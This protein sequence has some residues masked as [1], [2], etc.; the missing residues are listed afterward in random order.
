MVRESSTTLTWKALQRSLDRVV[1]VRALK[2]GSSES[3]R[4][5][6]EAVARAV[7]K[8]KHPN[9]IQAFD[10]ARQ[11]D[12]S[13][14]IVLEAV[15]G[16]TLAELL[17]RET[18]MD[19]VRVAKIGAGVADALDAAWK[20]TSLIH[21]NLKPENLCVTHEG[22][23]KIV[24]FGAATLIQPGV[25]PLQHDGGLIVGTPNYMA[26]EQAQ[27][28][29]DLDFHS[30][31]YGLGALLYHLVTGVA[32]FGYEP[33]PHKT[34]ELQVTGTL[35]S[36]RVANPKVPGSLETVLARLMMKDP[37]AR[38]DWWQDAVADLQ[39][40]SLGRPIPKDKGADPE[41]LGTL[42]P[43]APPRRSARRQSTS[44]GGA[45][46]PAPSR[47]S[48]LAEARSENRPSP[49]EPV[50][51][52]LWVALLVA[53]AGLAVYRWEHP[54]ATGL[55]FAIPG[56]EAVVP[57]APPPLPV[58][59]AEG[60]F[61]GTDASVRPSVTELPVPVS[62]APAPPAVP[63]PDPAQRQ[64]SAGLP[65]ALLDGVVQCLGRE[66]L[67]SA[68]GILASAAGKV[69][70]SES[71]RDAALRL[72]SSL[73]DPN[74]VV[75]SRFL[76]QSKGR[77]V[78]LTYRGRVV[79]LVP[80][81]YAAGYVGAKLL[82]ADGSSHPWSMGLASLPA[83][84]RLRLIGAAAAPSGDPAADA[85]LAILA[86]AADDRVL[87]RSMAVHVPALAPFLLH[88]ANR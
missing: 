59:G 84:E 86:V 54:E 70:T 20:Q 36:P 50:R 62:T 9:L 19:P 55:P 82:G 68:R 65:P 12:G 85:A 22:V 71:E 3:Q 42:A 5:A 18:Q 60:P 56:G 52:A 83:A 78:Q 61:P 63:L 15:E 39:R 14:Y 48:A 66:D 6:F 87:A 79:S 26:P 51:F 45:R 76:E 88:A 24:E 58:R 77:T 81:S 75:G 44:A 16:P 31:M 29:H 23:V 47:P 35:P 17:K 34:M 40:V 21:R 73:G 80:E 27:G 11:E 10:V 28:A 67:A 33:D 57:P 69:G 8:L 2:P 64:T 30:D 38:Y 53:L 37:H 43:F 46:T 4:E 13:S 41:A 25:D 1:Y 7:A 74:D 49:S 72:L 32:P